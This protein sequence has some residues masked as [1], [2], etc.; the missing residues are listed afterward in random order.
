MAVI[1]QLLNQAYGW[2]FPAQPQ[3]PKEVF[4]TSLS[5]FKDVDISEADCLKNCVEGVL[6]ALKPAECDLSDTSQQ[7]LD[8]YVSDFVNEVDTPSYLIGYEKGRLK[9]EFKK[10]LGEAITEKWAAVMAESFYRIPTISDQQEKIV[11]AQKWTHQYFIGVKYLTQCQDEGSSV[12]HGYFVGKLAAA[13]QS[14][15]HTHS[16]NEIQKRAETMKRQYENDPAGFAKR[17]EGLNVKVESEEGTQIVDKEIEQLAKDCAQSLLMHWPNIDENVAFLKKSI[18]AGYTI[19]S[20]KLDILDQDRQ[21]L[22]AGAL[23]KNS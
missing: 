15:F 12:I 11:A 21:H 2:V 3:T 19:V 7:L 1:T 22:F 13:T 10:R 20:M 4:K 18:W 16:H 14:A 6:K 5:K 8:S 17:L 23:K 9:V